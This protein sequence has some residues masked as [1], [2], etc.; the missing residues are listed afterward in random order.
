MGKIGGTI[1]HLGMT[2]VYGLFDIA[3]EN[4]HVEEVNHHFKC[5]VF[6]MG[7]LR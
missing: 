1:Y 3:M 4:P 6:L 7:N 5:V 2:G